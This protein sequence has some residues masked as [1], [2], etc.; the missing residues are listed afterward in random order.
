MKTKLI[1]FICMGF[2]IFGC[3]GQC[4]SSRQNVNKKAAEGKI[5]SLSFSGNS[6][7]RTDA[8]SYTLHETDGEILFN[9]F[10]FIRDSN[11][12]KEIRRELPVTGED[13]EALRKLCDNCKLVQKQRT[14]PPPKTPV[15]KLIASQIKDAPNVSLSVKWENGARYRESGMSVSCDNVLRKFFKD[16]AARVESDSTNH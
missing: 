10:Y 15:E 13:M 14:P 2:W 12:I 6:M 4:R 9:A 7:V 5:M 3:G 1:N 8:Y 11:G 16:L